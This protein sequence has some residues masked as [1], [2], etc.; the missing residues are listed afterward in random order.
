MQHVGTK[1]KYIICCE[2]PIE[3]TLEMRKL[4]LE[5]MERKAHE[6][7]PLYKVGE[8]QGSCYYFSH[9]LARYLQR[10]SYTDIKD[11]CGKFLLYVEFF[12]DSIV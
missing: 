7:M 12:G 6:Y 11:K 8:R 10:K 2:E 5:E 9:Y 1:S 4:V 3:G